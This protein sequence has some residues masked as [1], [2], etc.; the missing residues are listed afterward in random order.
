MLCLIQ[1]A[2]C[3]FHFL[4]ARVKLDNM[5]Q[6]IQTNDVAHIMSDSLIVIFL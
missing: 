6:N 1:I 2:A 3:D 5:R 4:S